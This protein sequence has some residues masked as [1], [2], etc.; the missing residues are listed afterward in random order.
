MGAP[1]QFVNFGEVF[2]HFTHLN[3]SAIRWSPPSGLMSGRR[4]RMFQAK[5]KI[6]RL[7]DQAAILSQPPAQAVTDVPSRYAVST[8]D[9]GEGQPP[10]R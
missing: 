3:W 10:V 6:A 1:Q 2:P 4:R 7:T 5:Q 9:G 8:W